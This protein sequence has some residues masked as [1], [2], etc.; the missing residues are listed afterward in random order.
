MAREIPDVRHVIIEEVGHMT[1]IEAPER[2]IKELLDFLETVAGT[3]KA[4]R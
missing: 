2:T 1:A 4:T 3:G